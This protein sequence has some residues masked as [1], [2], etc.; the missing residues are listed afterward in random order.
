MSLNFEFIAIIKFQDVKFE[1][2][3][4]VIKMKW[5][6]N[7]VET[8]KSEWWGWWGD[9]V[10]GLSF[11]C[12]AVPW[13]PGPPLFLYIYIYLKTINN[14]VRGNE[15]CR[16]V[17]MLSLQSSSKNPS[18]PITPVTSRGFVDIE[19]AITCLVLTQPHIE[20]WQGDRPS[21]TPSPRHHAYTMARC[22]ITLTDSFVGVRH[23][24]K[25][26]VIVSPQISI[27]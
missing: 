14:R 13:S 22:L 3:T 1:R 19:R 12:I 23:S 6:E 25:L 2:I 20:K 4:Y 27:V 8:W 11:F 26:S 17:P 21:P 10:F 5:R 18:H 24:T 9:G 7:D 15:D 16:L